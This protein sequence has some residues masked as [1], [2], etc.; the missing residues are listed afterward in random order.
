MKPLHHIIIGAVIFIISIIFALNIGLFVHTV[1]EVSLPQTLSD[2]TLTVSPR[3]CQEVYYSAPRELL[4][5]KIEVEIHV[6]GGDNKARVTLINPYGNAVFDNYCTGTCDFNLRLY[7]T[8]IYTIKICNEYSLWDV[9]LHRAKDKMIRL[10]ILLVE[11]GSGVYKGETGKYVRIIQ[12]LF[13][14]L[15]F[16]GLGEA[17]YG[18]VKY[19]SLRTSTKS[20]T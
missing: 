12:I 11:F 6:A 14:A 18:I 17:I 3:S 16:V 7:H 1:S 15:S 19:R 8:G 2:E 5:S 13:F 10:R 9:I 4:N 20:L